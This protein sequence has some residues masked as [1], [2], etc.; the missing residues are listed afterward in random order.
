VT[1]PEADEVASTP[2]RLLIVDDHELVRKGFA[3]TMAVDGRF[4]VVAE[5]GS[6]R[7]A[8]AALRRVRPDVAVVDLR[9]PDMRG[10]ELCA[11]LRERLPRTPVIIL[12]AY[13]TEDTVR[14][15]MKAGASAY[16]PKSADVGELLDVLARVVREESNSASPQIVERLH[17]LLGERSSEHR[18]SPRQARVLALAA[19]GLTYREIG[20]R[21]HISYGT[22]R[23]HMNNLKDKF[24]ARTRTEMIVKA[25]QAGVL[26]PPTGGRSS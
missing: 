22:V 19:E 18:I 3:A 4:E 11:E 2:I 6:G 21:L 8:L 16:V 9:L 25:I 15:A 14:A 13:G 5:T 1:K 24:G 12:S 7:D 23:F 10:E 26:E 17:D 20:A